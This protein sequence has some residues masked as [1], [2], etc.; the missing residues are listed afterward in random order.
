MTAGAQP[1]FICFF[2]RGLHDGWWSPKKLHTIR[3][4][5]LL[6]APR[7]AS[8]AP[9]KRIILE[10]S[11]LSKPGPIIASLNDPELAQRRLRLLVLSTYDAEQGG[12]R[13]SEFE[14]A[15]AQLTAAQRIVFTKLDLVS[16]TILEQQIKIACQLNPLA[17]LFFSTDRQGLVRDAF[18]ALDLDEHSPSWLQRHSTEATSAVPAH[19]RIHV[20]RGRFKHALYWDE[21][22]EWL[23]NLAGL[24]GE[25]LLRSKLLVDVRDCDEPIL[26]QSV[27]T[28]FSSPRRMS[29]QRTLS[30]VF[31]IITRDID[32]AEIN[33]QMTAYDSAPK[34]TLE[35]LQETPSIDKLFSKHLPVSPESSDFS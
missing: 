32:S 8:A 20:M 25:R 27:G 30:Q 31:V 22:S 3:A 10:T 29:Q 33:R 24:C 23:D 26:I 19:P 12:L 11:G 14:E 17:H 13:A 21:L 4:S 18:G 1:Q 15:S 7:P 35:P 2:D 9:L 34:V 6:D 28:T 16:S 5:R